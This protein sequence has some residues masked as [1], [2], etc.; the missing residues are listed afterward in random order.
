[1]IIIIFRARRGTTIVGTMFSPTEFLSHGNESRMLNSI[2]CM[3]TYL[4]EPQGCK[5]FVIFI[6]LDT[7]IE[8]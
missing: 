3:L 1:M 5:R 2:M 6:Q 7:R 4:P 8:L